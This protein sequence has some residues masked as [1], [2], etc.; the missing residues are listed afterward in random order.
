M[1]FVIQL[2]DDFE[3]DNVE[4]DG[5]RIDRLI[6]EVM[7]KHQ[8]CKYITLILEFMYTVHTPPFCRSF[9]Y[10]EMHSMF[11]TIGSHTTAY[12]NPLY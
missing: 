6:F 1:M 3:D 10:S 5:A 11:Y 4:T 12:N 7:T 2:G 8:K 9:L